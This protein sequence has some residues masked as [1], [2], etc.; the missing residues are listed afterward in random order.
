MTVAISTSGAAPALAALL[1]EGL[2]ALLPR[3]L[4][5]WM[6]EARAAEGPLDVAVTGHSKG[7]ALAPVVALWLQELLTSPDAAERWDG[8]RGAR[9]SAWASRSAV[10][11]THTLEP[12]CH[13]TPLDEAGF[14]QALSERPHALRVEVRR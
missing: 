12:R 3:D 5:R 2:D 6:W 4:A 11:Q 7:G 9:V 13:V 14:A 10:R 8:E 1:R